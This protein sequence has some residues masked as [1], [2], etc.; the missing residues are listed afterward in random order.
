MAVAFFLLPASLAEVA[1]PNTP[2][3]VNYV[4]GMSS[5][6]PQTWVRPWVWLAGM[7]IGLPLLIYGPTHLALRTWFHQ[8]TA[9]VVQEQQ[10]VGGTH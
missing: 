8:R 9:Q 7:A 1:D 2:V 4:W 10:I 6:A 3:N 5:E